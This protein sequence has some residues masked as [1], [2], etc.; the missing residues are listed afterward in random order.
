[1][2][3]VFN[4]GF[5]FNSEKDNDTNGNNFEKENISI[6]APFDNC[7]DES[8]EDEDSYVKILF[9]IITSMDFG[10]VS[11][12]IK[13]ELMNN[14]GKHESDNDK[15]Y[16]LKSVSLKA[17]ETVFFTYLLYYVSDSINSLGHSYIR[18]VVNIYE[19]YL[20]ITDIKIIEILSKK[21]FNFVRYILACIYN[22]LE[23]N[24]VDKRPCLRKLYQLWLLNQR[25]IMIFFD[26]DILKFIIL[27]VFIF[28]VVKKKII[29]FL[30]KLIPINVSLKKYTFSKQIFELRII[31]KFINNIV[32]RFYVSNEVVIN[33]YDVWI[34]ILI[35]HYFN[36]FYDIKNGEEICFF[37]I[38]FCQN[39]KNL[40]V[41]DLNYFCVKKVTRQKTTINGKLEPKIKNIFKEAMTWL[42]NAELIAVDI[43]F[44]PDIIQKI[45]KKNPCLEEINKENLQKDLLAENE[46]GFYSVDGEIC[47]SNGFVINIVGGKLYHNK[48]KMFFSKFTL[49]KII[50]C[51][52]VI[53]AHSQ[54]VIRLNLYTYN[55]I[56]TKEI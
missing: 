53:L 4:M 24:D 5:L 39:W 45:I 28:K 51:F 50:L 12:V 37:T 38:F 3:K 36:I 46:I 2:L 33:T 16:D 31:E 6:D 34:A 56:G 35:Y 17:F 7:L 49:L 52:V 30:N 19:G 47:Y 41:M 27:L 1:T 40:L 48:N 23:L 14:N 18:N 22:I 44:L 29:N 42:Y 15:E 9:L 20:S 13:N 43:E 25:R 32:K 10:S 26:V 11:I 8:I 21:S 54:F 55:K